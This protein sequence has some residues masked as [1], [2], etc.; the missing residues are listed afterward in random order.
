MKDLDL[1]NLQ[2]CRYKEYDSSIVE[3]YVLAKRDSKNHYLVYTINGNRGHSGAGDYEGIQQDGYNFYITEK[4]FKLL[5]ND[6]K[7]WYVSEDYFI[8]IIEVENNTTNIITTVDENGKIL[9]T[10]D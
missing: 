7:M 8:N 5:R 4:E 2:K 9:I 3:G 6:S 10:K 1:N